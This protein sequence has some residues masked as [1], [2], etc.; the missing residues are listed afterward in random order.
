MSADVA[1]YSRLMG[2][3]EDATITALNECRAIFR[4][5]IEFHRGR[6]VDTTGD[7]VLAVFDSVVEA[8]QCANEVQAE[9]AAQNEDL[10]DDRRMLFRI[11]VNLGDVV[12]Q[13]DGT[14][15]GDGVNV[16]ARL[17]S[18][19]EPGGV[20]I[21]GMAREATEGKLDIGFR[22][23]GKHDVKNITKPVHVYQ[24]LTDGTAG[25]TVKPS[26][27]R[28]TTLIAAVAAMVLMVATVAVWQVTRPPPTPPETVA[29]PEDLVLALPTGPTIAVMPFENL[30]GEAVLEYFGDGLT[31][32]LITRLSRFPRFFVIARNSTYQYKGRAVDVREV[33]RDLGANY[34]VE[35]SVRKSGETIRVTVQ[36]LDAENGTHL[37]A[38][39][40][41]R[42]LT[43]ANVFEIQD[44][45]TDRV[46]A[47][48]ADARGILWEAGA[49]AVREK[50]TENL[51]A[52]EC[53]LLLIAYF[54]VNTPDRHLEVQNCAERAVETDP[55]YAGAWVA[56]GYVA[57][58]ES[59]FGFNQR[60]RSLERALEAARRAVELDGD[61]ALAHEILAMVYFHQHDLDL[62]RAEGERAIALNP[63]NSWVLA[64]I[65]TYLVW[66]GERERGSAMVK[67][68]VAL[69]PNHPGWYYLGLS[70]TEY[71]KE[72]Y[73]KAV[74]YALKINLP[75]FHW[76]QVHLAAAYGQ[77]GRTAEGRATIDQLLK[78]RPDFAEKAWEEW[79][80]FNVPDEV[81]RRSLDG[82]RK[83]GLDVPE[84]PPPATK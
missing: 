25:T 26:G 29:A 28:R 42:D 2:Q 16:A 66:T 13:D 76:A 19:A 68:A 84:E 71:H 43:A 41:D 27:G 33:G 34:I 44:E 82:L 58:D 74:E 11:G 35:G 78:I 55:N 67:K 59:R 31:E 69:N 51:D 61:N 4:D 15:Y 38:E 70:F 65:G 63:N 30:S 7:S 48:I 79:R 24:V 9:L 75:D 80:T 10:P 1:G 45:I 72:N 57:L 21:S 40:Y 62:F 47:T 73:E 64:T 39:T 77:L 3:D 18:I 49:A 5:K 36:L 37:W 22:D 50:R 60:P 12:E 8:V 20:T 83:A 32:D 14:I 46:S 53:V 81:I 54:D 17:E 6:V 56:L 52:Y 23:L